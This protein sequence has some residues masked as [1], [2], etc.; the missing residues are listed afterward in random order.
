QD[1]YESALADEAASKEAVNAREAA[2]VAARAKIDRAEADLKSARANVDVYKARLKAAKVNVAYTEIRSPYD[3]VVTMRQYHVG[4]FIRSAA[5]SQGPPLLTVAK[6]DVMRVV[7]KVAD[8]DVPFTDAGDPAVVT[9]DALPGL[10]LPGKVSRISYTEDPTE[11][12]M[13]TE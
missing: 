2:A 9:L 4:D 8:L 7:T 1:A 3:G 13:R 11:R 10:E 5:D 6:T 12:T